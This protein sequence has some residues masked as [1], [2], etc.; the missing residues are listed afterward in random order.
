M[1]TL[2]CDCKDELHRSL[3]R[4]LGLTGPH[5]ARIAPNQPSTRVLDQQASET[6]FWTSRSAW[7]ELP[8]PP[9][10]QCRRRQAL[11]EVALISRPVHQRICLYNLDM[12]IA[13]TRTE[14]A[15]TT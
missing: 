13:L 5:L 14:Q 12:G 7:I 15:L 3:L 1:Y 10:C 2:D 4:W 6:M 8:A 11:V 9:E